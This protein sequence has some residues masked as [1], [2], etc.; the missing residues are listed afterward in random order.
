MSGFFGGSIQGLIGSITGALKWSGSAFA[1]AATADLS[2]VT[3]AATWTPT[4]Q[5]GAALTFVSVN[6][7][8]CKIGNMVFVCGTLVYPSTG[9][10]NAA[11]ISLPVAVPNQSYAAIPGPTIN[12]A[13]NG[14][15]LVPTQNT[16]PGVAAFTSVSTGGAITNNTLSS[17]KIQFSMMYP[18]S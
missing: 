14:I 8:Y 2:D 9:N 10:T 11:A 7:T 13:S 12:S 4:D 17:K 3:A 6:A 5:S 16:S 1:Q 15:M 18:A